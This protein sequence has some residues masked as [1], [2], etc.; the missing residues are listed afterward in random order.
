M[1]STLAVLRQERP[2]ARLLTAS[3]ISG[4]GDWFNSVAVLSLILTLGHSPLAVA[5]ML[6]LRSLP[7]LVLGALAGIAADRFSRKAILMGCD[8]ARM[9]LALSLALASAMR[10][11][12]PS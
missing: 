1:T 12:T 2:F 3:T 9:T 10:A 5:I 6:L 4:L 8:L 11:L 7:F